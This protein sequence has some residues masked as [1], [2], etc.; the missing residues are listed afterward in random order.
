MNLLH[1]IETPSLASSPQGVED[2]LH[3]LFHRAY[4]SIRLGYPRTF[5]DPFPRFALTTV[6]FWEGARVPVIAS[7]DWGNLTQ[8][9]LFSAP[10]HHY[11][12]LYCFRCD[13]PVIIGNRKTIFWVLRSDR[14]HVVA[15]TPP[16]TILESR[17]DHEHGNRAAIPPMQLIFMVLNSGEGDV[18]FF[19]G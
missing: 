10:A 5:C 1:K 17:N 19:L 14:A 8:F 4:S 7:K 11:I 18:W 3:F 15:V 13:D 16:S 9:P 2:E 6:S 12:L